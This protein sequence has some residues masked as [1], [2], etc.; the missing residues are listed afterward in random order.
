MKKY[1]GILVFAFF[2]VGCGDDDGLDVIRVE[3]RRL[4]EVVAEDEMEIMEF[5]QTHFYNDDQF[6]NPPAGFDFKVVVDTIAGENANRTPL[7]EQIDTTL[8][9][10]VSDSRFNLDNGEENIPHT[11][12]IIRGRQGQGEQATIADSTFVRFEGFRLDRTIFQNDTEIGQWTDLQGIPGTAQGG[13]VKG[14]QE[15]VAQFRAG[16]TVVEGTD[17]TFTIE[18]FGAGLIIMP[19]GLGFFNQ[20]TTGQPFTPLVFSISLFALET[21]DHD[22]DNISSIL[23]DLNGDKDLFN[24]DTDGDG[25]PN[26]LDFDDDGDGIATRDEITIGDDGTVSFPDSDG[27]GTPDYLD[28]DS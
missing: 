24:D 28:S 10:L 9:I 2:L 7:A 5:L 3:N 22:R 23:E 27:D 13:V 12:Y 6:A 1:F 25:A 16:T 11:L 17:G 18:D 20:F 21:A 14:F 26:Y 19:S 15:G 4:S 8:T